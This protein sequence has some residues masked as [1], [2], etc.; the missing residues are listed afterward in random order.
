MI[1]RQQVQVPTGAAGEFSSRQL[2]VLICIS[3]SI[4]LPHPPKPSVT[5]VASKRSWPFSQKCRWQVPA[6]HTGTL[7]MWLWMNWHCKLVHS[8]MVHTKHALRRQQFPKAPAMQKPNSAESTLLRSVNIQKCVIKRATA[9]HSESHVTGA[10]WGC[11]R[12]ENS[13]VRYRNDQQQDEHFHAHGVLTWGLPLWLSGFCAGWNI[14]SRSATRR[15]R[16]DRIKPGQRKEKPVF[17]LSFLP[18][19]VGLL[20]INMHP[21]ITI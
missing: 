8:C 12:T 20:F 15:Y 17:F 10:Q 18:S 2:S 5:M 14:L 21:S 9:T 19:T 16:G 7:C 13:A 6:K 4:P 3:L 1:E 11:S